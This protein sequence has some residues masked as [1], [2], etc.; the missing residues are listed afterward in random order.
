MDILITVGLAILA[1]CGG[2]WYTVGRL[3]SEVKEHNRILAEIRKSLE[4]LMTRSR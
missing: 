2:L 3:T 1:S 4:I